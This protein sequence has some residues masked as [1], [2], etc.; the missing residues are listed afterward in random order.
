MNLIPSEESLTVE[1]KSDVKKSEDTDVVEAVVGLANTRGGELY[2]GVENDGTITGL[3]P[4]R[5]NLARLAAVIAN[6]TVPPLLVRIEVIEAERPVVKV[7]VPFSRTIVSTANGRMLRR[8]LK[9]DG[10][11]ENIPLYPHEVSGRLSALGLLDY[12]A[13]AVV[14]ATV[15]DFDV[16][17][18][19]RLRRIIRTHGGEPVLLEL[20]D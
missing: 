12:S 1:F 18:R 8:R 9:A 14:N 3:H 7:E 19:Q 4:S 13:Q 10:T 17:E 11:P 16:L 15:D 6:K 2:I 20:N 5:Q